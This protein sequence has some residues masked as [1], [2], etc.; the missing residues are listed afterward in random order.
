[1][2]VGP[3]FYG[4]A[5]T[6]RVSGAGPSTFGLAQSLRTSGV[7]PS[8]TGA[9]TS[10]TGPPVV[11]AIEPR[12]GLSVGDDCV[13]IRGHNFGLESEGRTTKVLF[14]GV[15]APQSG[16]IDGDTVI[17]LTPQGQLGDVDVVIEV[18]DSTTDVLLFA[19]TV[20]NGFTYQ[21]PNVETNRDELASEDSALLVLTRELI[22]DMRRTILANVVYDTHP[23]YVD[24]FSVTVPEEAQAS[25]PNLKILGPEV[26]EDSFYSLR[27]AFTLETPSGFQAHHRPTTF[28]LDYRFVGIGKTKGEAINIWDALN[29][30][31]NR[32]VFLVV[33]QDGVNKDNGTLSFELNPTFDERGEFLTTTRQGFYQFEGG[34]H[35][36]GVHTVARPLCL[37]RAVLECVQTIVQIPPS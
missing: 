31:L 1:M 17:A 14:G 23:E 29:L 25:A 11:E 15:E 10:V 12:V 21:R 30:W 20:D 24:A 35:L 36:R 7:G 16:A 22:K 4:V 18:R 13:T 27:Q 26:S 9:T 33:P 3:S 28:R 6:P 8:Y 32:T 34:F 37:S 2:G 19:V 5:S